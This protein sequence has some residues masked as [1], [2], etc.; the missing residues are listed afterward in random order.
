[1]TDGED[2]R[3]WPPPAPT[4]GL[5]P[6]TEANL[7]DGVFPAMPFRAA[8]GRFAIGTDANVQIDAAAELRQLEYAQRLAVRGR[9]LL[10]APGGSTGRALFA[11]ALAGGSRALG[12]PAGGLRVG[13]PAD[14][15]TLAADHPS[16]LGRAGDA[17][18]DGWMFAAARPAIEDVWAR[19]VRVV[20]EGRHVAMARLHRAYAASLCRLLSD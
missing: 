11:G 14:I 6:L 13:A 16:L 19:G 4:V 17:L 12:R 5:C 3:A 15:V 9:N 2:R 8:G 20:R 1:M 18:L 7:G 10:A